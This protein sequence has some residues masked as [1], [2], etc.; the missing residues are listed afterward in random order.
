M[1]HMFSSSTC[2]TCLPCLRALQT[3]VSACLRPLASY[4]PSFLM[5]VT[6]LPFLFADVLSFFYIPSLF[7]VPYLP[8]FLYLL[9]VSSVFIAFI[10]FWGLKCLPSFL[11]VLHA[12]IFLRVFTLLSVS[13]SWQTL[14]CNKLESERTW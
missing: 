6:R 8:S 3:H 5:W 1:H 12:L 11:R 10:S 14:P 7:R 2:L 9:N 13:N 4:V